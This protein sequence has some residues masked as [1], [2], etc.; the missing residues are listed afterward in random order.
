[1]LESRVLRPNL[2][3]SQTHSRSTGALFCDRALSD[4]V[5]RQRKCCLLGNA[6]RIFEVV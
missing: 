3:A 4:V 6:D 5:S 2:H 1:M